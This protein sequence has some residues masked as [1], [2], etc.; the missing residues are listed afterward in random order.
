MNVAKSNFM[1]ISAKQ[2]D[3][4]LQS[5]SKDLDLKIRDNELE[6]VEKTKYLDVQFECS[7]V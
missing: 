7:L 6:E 3:N 5:Q 2:K 4:T 1:I